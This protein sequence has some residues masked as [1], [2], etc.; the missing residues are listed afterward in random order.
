MLSADA[1]EHL[2]RNGDPVERGLGVGSAV[3][4]DRAPTQAR[5]VACHGREHMRADRLVGIAD[6]DRDLNGRI[7]QLAPVGNRLCVLRRT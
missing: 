3:D 5:A 1:I 4:R 2:L 6:R 7:E